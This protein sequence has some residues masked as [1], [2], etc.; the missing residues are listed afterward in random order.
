[1][2]PT[3]NDFLVKSENNGKETPALFFDLIISVIF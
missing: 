1:M 2:S 3:A